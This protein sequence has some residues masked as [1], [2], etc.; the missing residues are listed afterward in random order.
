MHP[1]GSSL[2]HSGISA[3]AFIL[4]AKRN[5]GFVEKLQT[6]DARSARLLGVVATL[7]K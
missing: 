7:V 3:C 1:S 4:L 2:Q 5:L 6:F